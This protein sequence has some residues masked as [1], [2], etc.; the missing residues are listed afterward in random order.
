MI[1]DDYIKYYNEYT[2]KYGKNT[3]VLIE[4][5]KFF[6]LYS[7]DSEG[8]N[9]KNISDL[10]DIQHTKKN[11]SLP[12]CNR[13]NPYMAGVPSC[14]IK[15]Y[16]DIL[17]D[18]NYTIILVEQVTGPPFVKREVTKIISNST[19][20]DNIN[21]NTVENN[22]LSC[23]YFSSGYDR[24]KNKYL[25]SCCCFLDLSTGEI[26]LQ[27]FLDYTSDVINLEEM[28]RILSF[29]RPKELVLISTDLE[30]IT[31]DKI[32]K[33]TTTISVGCVHNYLA[34]D[35]NIF[36]KLSY[37]NTILRKIYPNTGLLSQIEYLDLENRPYSIICFTYIINF[38][39][40]HN[41][42]IVKRLNKPKIK[43]NE[44]YLLLVNNA[45]N[46]LNIISN[47]SGKNSSIHNLL[48]HCVTAIGKRIF[49]KKLLNP[50]TNTKQI[51]KCYNMVEL[52]IH[53]NE[54]KKY[55][56]IFGNIYDLERLFRKIAIGTLQP[57][58]F[59]YINTSLQGVL[60]LFTTLN[61]IEKIDLNLVEWGITTQNK[62]LEM[63]HYYQSKFDLT[64][65]SKY[66]IDTITSNFFNIGILPDVDKINTDI[67]DIHTYFNNL[68]SDL[69]SDEKEH[70]FK[71]E[72]IKNEYW[73]T[74]TK[75]RY[76]TF[77]GKKHVINFKDKY[78]FSLDFLDARPLSVNNKTQ[79]RILFPSMYEKQQNLNNLQEQLAKLVIKQYL[80]ELSYIADNYEVLFTKIVQ[81]IGN[82]DVFVANAK[83]AA[84]YKYCK[85]V[86]VDNNFENSFLKANQ[87]RHP[88]IEQIQDLEYIPN[89]I[90][91]GIDNQTGILLYGINAVGKSSLMKSIGIAVL[92]AQSG[93]YVAAEKFQYSP[94]KSIF[95]RIPS[96]DDI[97]KG[98][99]TFVVEMMELRTIL[100][101]ATHNS[102]VICDELA[103][104]T[105][106][107]SAISIVGASIVQ[108]ENRDISFI[109][110]SHLH[111]V[112]NLDN[113]KRLTRLQIYHMNV[114]YDEV[115][116]VLIYNRKLVPGNGDTLY[117]LEVCKSLDL[118]SEFLLMVNQIRQQYLGMHNNIVN[119]KTSK[120]SADVYIDI[121]EICKKNTEEV[122]HIKEQSTADNN[123]FIEN[124]HKNRKFNLLN[125]CSD[126]HNNI[127]SGNI[128]VNGYKKTSDGIILDVV[129]NPKSTSIDIN[130]IVITLK[131]Q[132]LSTASIIK[133]IKE[134]HNMDIT[135]YRV[136]KILKNK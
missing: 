96:G 56:I 37:Q 120:Y 5:G 93:M 44:D 33:W 4:V 28:S 66:N 29:Y 131:R 113:I 102:L 87:L 76:D 43:E 117:G 36:C 2:Q 60:D 62:L 91:L 121:C 7:T 99:S 24:L 55:A 126:C 79:L 95:T 133:K 8:P 130:D 86:I 61:K 35:I 115:K 19:Y 10:L 124:Y 111:E 63:M 82:L 41:E 104:G 31:I 64:E 92:M 11:K 47:T 135:I 14:A 77:K 18:N 12:E 40:Q 116:K 70:V 25:I 69:N 32:C 80:T 26:F 16:L 128:K 6:E 90:T 101:C 108:L 98:H 127:H 73:I 20:L 45:I 21:T 13:N 94:Y 114:T 109:S 106:L 22:Y 71:L 72:S 23:I 27:E 42:N 57:V 118:S 68:V 39:Y 49:K 134:C 112:S 53:N 105:E 52:L 1:Y 75:K 59:T 89:D 48:N 129:N 78:G 122:H 125:V 88:L 119:Q 103:V 30:T 58:E 51:E 132:G 46:H 38:A 83:S 34:H 67:S 54:Y 136:L 123:G 110:A 15:K 107:T 81:F 84:I 97:F 100:K 3:I 50:L 9:I 17:V 85:P 65:M 74:I